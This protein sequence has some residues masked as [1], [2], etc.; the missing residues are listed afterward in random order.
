MALSTPDPNT[1]AA[2]M[3]RGGPGAASGVR[4]RTHPQ[5]GVPHHARHLHHAVLRLWFRPRVVGQENVPATG[6]VILAPVHRSFADF[7]FTA[8][9]TDRKLFF[10]AKDSLWKNQ[11]LGTAAALRRRLP[12]APGVGR[13]RG[14]ATGRRGPRAGPVPGP[15][16]RGH[17][18]GGGG[19]REPH[20]GGR[21]PLGPHGRAHRA[22][23]HRRLG[24]V[25]AQG[26]RHPQAVHHCGGHRP[27]PARRRP[28]PGAGGSPARP[29]MPPPRSWSGSC[30]RST[31]RPR[32]RRDA[33][34]HVRHRGMRRVPG[35]GAHGARRPGPP[36]VPGLRLGRHGR[37]R[38][39]HA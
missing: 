22:H 28:V 26:K 17:P 23:R 7:G 39:G 34:E 32:R 33:T 5:G 2:P 38:P 29:S 19:D 8:F 12:R 25:D 21:V 1:R 27:R 6:P 10:M 15:V 13:P 9:C 18:P 36:R 11:W 30:R 3:R 20:G 14:A 35:L 16:P 24:P 37:P 4:H 31:T